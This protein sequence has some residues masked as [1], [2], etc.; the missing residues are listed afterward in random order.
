MATA[1]KQPVPIDFFLML[2]QSGSMG[3]D[4]NIGSTTASKW[5]RAI[6]AVSA[7]MS[8]PAAAG[9]AASLQYFDLAGA[10]C[11]TGA[12]YDVSEIPMSG[13]GYVSLPSNAFNSSLNSHFPSTN[14]SIEGG[15]RGITGFTGRAPN[16]RPGRDTVGILITDDLPT[17]CD[18]NLTNLSNLLQNH[19]TNTGIVTLVFGM[20]AANFAMVE[21]LATG[22]SAPLHPDTV[23]GITDTCG[24]GNGPCRHWNLGNGNGNVIAEALASVTR[25]R[26][27]CRYSLAAPDGGAFPSSSVSVE[28][29]TD[30][31]TPTP[32]PQVADST[33]CADGGWYLATPTPPGFVEL[34][35][36]TCGSLQLA[37]DPTVRVTSSACEP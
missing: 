4:C 25:R 31:S 22:G 34:C 17:G 5:C 12:G 28:W 1:S 15:I 20:T 2:D 9:Q 36:V 3:T 14:S 8:S 6:N 30:A 35:S 13:N 24:N 11:V 26:L 21:T 33:A 27:N 37:V 19:H 16:R 7:Y 29:A 10:S 23:N 18:S 32:I